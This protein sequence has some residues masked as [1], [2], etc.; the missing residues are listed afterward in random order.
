MEIEIV[1]EIAKMLE[2]GI[3]P[4]AKQANLDERLTRSGKVVAG[5]RNRLDL[6][7]QELLRTAIVCQATPR[8]VR[9]CAQSCRTFTW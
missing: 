1:G 4:N 3:W 5:T 8:N 6:Q 7:L 2:L 9:L